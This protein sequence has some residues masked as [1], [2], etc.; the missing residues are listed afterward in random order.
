[1]EIDH[2]ALNRRK[3]V[4]LDSVFPVQFRLVGAADEQSFLSVWLQGFTNDIGKGGLCLRVNNLSSELIQTMKSQS[5]R[6]ILEI[7]S[8]LGRQ[9]VFARASVSWIKDV[10]VNANKY[11]IGLNYDSIERSGNTRLMRYVWM[12]KLFI[13]VVYSIILIFSAALVFN[14]YV[15]AKLI[16][17]NKSLI[18]QLVNI[19]Q[20]SI[21]AKQKITSIN[22]D[23]EDLQRKIEALQ[24]RIKTVEDE[25][26]FLEEGTKLEEAKTGKKVEELRKLIEQ[27]RQEKAPLQEKLI[28][29]QHRET[30]VTE[31]LL[32]LDEKKSVLQK[33][34]FN[35][36]YQWLA[37]H[38]NPRTGLVMS[39]EGDA[40]VDGWAFTYDQSLAIQAYTNF[41]DYERARKTLEFY[42]HKAKR[43]EG[44]FVNAYDAKDGSPAEYIVH[45]GPNIW[46]GIAV[47]HYTKKTQDTKYMR[48]AEEI[49]QVMIT[50]QGQDE[51]G[52][53]RG[54]P[55]I[56]WYSTEHNLDAYAFFDMLYTITK[57]QLYA[58]ARDRVF[59][60]LIGHIYDKVDIPIIRGKGD[61]TIATD[62]YAW[63]I[64]AL[65]PEKL[66]ENR[67]H[68]D[69]IIEFAEENCVVE[70]PSVGPSGEAIKIKGFD[71]AP[72]RHL[73]RGGVIS[74]EWTAQMILSFKIMSNYYKKKDMLGKAKVYDQKANEYMVDLCTLIISS[75]SP[76]GQGE[77]CLPY[78]SAESVDTG[79]GWSTPAGKKTGAVSGTVYT[80]FAYYNYNPL[81]LE[82]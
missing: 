15:N 64:A 8:P 37:L 48:L 62:T 70:V 38:Q 1:M 5:T 34:N 55:N 50:L 66:E 71:F 47:L 6:V 67:M 75:P 58:E 4:R 45:S 53:I 22:K 54:G 29:L 43:R 31:E 63:A 59:R 13:P 26:T 27:L 36:M 19:L 20:E 11:L 40:Q 12:K 74:T 73:S 21:I 69:K 3:Y 81:E 41:S 2:E 46:L 18:S 14:S 79:H 16:Q 76:S 68:P 57:N 10:A 42:A 32:R 23:K 51:E 49:A 17:G 7:E 61:S 78:A 77:G 33:E 39:F 9:P 65:G 80:L 72:Q 44:L 30:T 35:K 60:W 25:K 52:G 28:D 24:V 56:S 82:N